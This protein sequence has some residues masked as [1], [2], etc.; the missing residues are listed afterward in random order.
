VEKNMPPSWQRAHPI[1]IEK[2]GRD[3]MIMEFLKV[4][5]A[6]FAAV[7][8][9]TYVG[10]GII[11]WVMVKLKQSRERVD[12]MNVHEPPVTLLIAAYNE[13]EDIRA[14]AVNTLELD[15]PSD[16]CDILFVTDGSNDGTEKIP[17]RIHAR[18]ARARTA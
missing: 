12:M 4:L 3:G 18:S 11:L 5:F 8:I 14:K 13:A 1:S 15:Y 6:L 10:Y 16:Q 9:Y 17:P 7:V 2:G